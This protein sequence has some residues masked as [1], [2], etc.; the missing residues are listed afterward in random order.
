M[1]NVS[2]VIGTKLSSQQFPRM[3]RQLRVQYVSG[4]E[5]FSIPGLVGEA[6]NSVSGQMKLF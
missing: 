3:A 6:R 5:G 4:D 2:R 1:K